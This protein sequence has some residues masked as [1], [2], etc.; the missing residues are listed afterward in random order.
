MLSSEL[1]AV[2][3]R[4][5]LAAVRVSA[6]GHSM[7]GLIL[8]QALAE[9]VVEP[10]L[11]SI[12]WVAYITLACPHLGCQ[13]LPPHVR[14]FGWLAGNIYSRAYADM[15][16]NSNDLYGL[17]D[18]PSLHALRKFRHRH[19]YAN[20]ADHLVPWPTASLL[21]QD[22]KVVLASRTVVPGHPHVLSPLTLH[23]L[24]A[25]E[26]HDVVTSHFSGDGKTVAGMHRAMRG[27][28]EWTLH[29]VHFTEAFCVAHSAIIQHSSRAVAL[30]SW[31]TD[32]VLHVAGSL[33]SLHELS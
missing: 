11:T 14:F 27:V 16:M 1:R 30:S 21:L 18:A 25:Q 19:L 32:V 2:I 4:Y 3:A 33:L 17:C 28:G 26:P 22:A 24:E 23:P 20:I 5:P 9:V 10:D 6:V 8:R 15:L 29:P 31:G 7:G 12:E 13:G